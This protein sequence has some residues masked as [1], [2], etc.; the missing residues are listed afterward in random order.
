VTP[1]FITLANVAFLETSICAILRPMNRTPN[2]SRCRSGIVAVVA[3]LLVALVLATAGAADPGPRINA[4]AGV[5]VGGYDP[6]AYFAEGRAVAGDAKIA[7]RWRGVR[8]HFSTPAH[9]AAFEADPRAYLPQ[10]GGFCALA[11]S[12]GRAVPANPENWVIL[13]G[14]LY[15]TETP[16]GK[17]RLDANPS[18]LV[19]RARSNWSGVAAA[20]E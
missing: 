11:M 7:L 16:V 8:W 14:R 17:S 19:A 6:V 2:I 12:E 4:V 20:A 10:F 9:R 1:G 5:A 18:M 13:E 15:L 3:A